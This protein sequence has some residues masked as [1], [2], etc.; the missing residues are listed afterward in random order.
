M[1]PSIED[2][3]FTARRIGRWSFA[4]ALAVFGFLLVFHLRGWPIGPSGRPIQI[5]FVVFW[6]AAR[7]ALHQDIAAVYDW[8]ALAQA[9]IDLTGLPVARPFVYPPTF[10]LTLAPFAALPYVPAFFA[11]ISLTFAAYLAAIYAIVPH[12]LAV[13]LA[14][15]SPVSLWNLIGGQN[16]FLSA[17]LIGGA[18]ALME[19]RPIVA[20]VLLGS[21]AYKPHLALL[22]PLV[23]V[24]TGNWRVIA[25]AAATAVM[26]AGAC[27]LAFGPESWGVF[28]RAIPTIVDLE[29]NENFFTWPHVQSAYGLARWLGA[30]QDGAGA[31]HAAIA[32]GAAAIVCWIWLRP[33]AYS[34]KAAALSTG[35]LLMT[36]YLLMYDLA[37]I[38]VPVAFLVLAGLR[39]AFPRGERIALVCI[40]AS[41]LVQF[42]IGRAP[43][44][45]IT[46]IALLCL[47]VARAARRPPQAVL[48]TS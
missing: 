38:A 24:L 17:A 1:T 48:Q 33:G 43:V 30:G 8:A 6:S 31:I 18:L 34:V 28:F 37:V 23:L 11:W 2:R 12:R 9:E 45:P 39:S 10:L 13:L 25:S 36:P 3:L 44:G 5:D 19:T 29:S 21:L 20:G 4:T 14:A 42:A 41:P 15:A 16:G 7:L 26:L 32:L 35:T 40:A 27:G 46:L 22:F 47:I